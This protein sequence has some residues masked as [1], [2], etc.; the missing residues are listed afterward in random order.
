MNIINL[1]LSNYQTSKDYEALWQ[2]AQSQSVIC[3]IDYCTDLISGDKHCCRDVAHTAYVPGEKWMRV[4]AR[5]I[6][7][8]EAETKESFCRQCERLQLEWLPPL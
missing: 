4:G 5:G 3:I 8:I 1:K 2:L 7:Y 6:G